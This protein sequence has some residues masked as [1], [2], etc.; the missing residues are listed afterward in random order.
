M[1]NDVLKGKIPN[2]VLASASPR[3]AELLRQIG[4]EFRVLPSQI[5]EPD[6]K[7]H[8]IEAVK[9]I[10]YQ[11]A[12]VVADQLES[13]LVIGADTTVVANQA[14]IGKPASYQQA[15]DSLQKLSGCRHQVMTGVAL[16]DVSQK[17]EMVWS[18]TTSVFF[19]QLHNEEIEAY[20][21][22][23]EANDKAGAYGIQGEAATFVNRIEGCYFNVVGLPLASLT[24]NLYQIYWS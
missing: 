24:E 15:V 2:I 8:P 9:H 23:G 17:T 3:R 1:I 20:V 13:G 4:L 7:N 21:A 22:N 5:N 10:A 11:K 19:R 12:E 18:E 6:I 14:I 16:I